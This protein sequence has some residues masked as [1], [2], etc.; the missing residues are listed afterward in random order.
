MANSKIMEKIAA[1]LAKT[2]ENGASEQEAIAA[3]K[4]AQRLMAKYHVEAVE[5]QEKTENIDTESVGVTR[6]WQ[7]SLAKVIADNTCCRVV[8]TVG[9]Q[10][11]ASVMF[12]GRDSDRKNAIALW[13]MF[14]KLIADGVRAARQA[15]TA[16]YGHSQKV[17]GAYAIKYIQAI[18]EEMGEQCRALALVIPEDVDNAVSAKFPKLATKHLSY[19]VNTGASYMASQMGYR[20]GKNAASRKRLG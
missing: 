2:V 12:F 6:N 17:E 10:R 4:L 7:L 9:N 15:A 18:K 1:L 5:L 20:D 8:R 19:R 16:R 3:A 13:K 14:A 11:R